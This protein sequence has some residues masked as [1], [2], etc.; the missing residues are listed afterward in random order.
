MSVASTRPSRTR[1]HGTSRAT[2]GRVSAAPANSGFSP[3]AAIGEIFNGVQWTP[4]LVAFLYYYFVV[5]TYYLPGADVGMV[6]AVAMLVLQLHEIRI[7]RVL[8]LLAF[9]VAWMWLSYLTSPKPALAL[10]QTWTMTKLWIVAFVAFNVLRTR[11]QI[12]FFLAFATGCFLLF[13]LRGALLNYFLG[14]STGGRAA[15]NYTYN[16]PNDLAGFAIIFASIA[17]SLAPITR[18]RFARYLC[19]ASAG[20][21]VMLIFFTQSRGALLATGIIASFLVVTRFRRPS[22]VLGTVVTLLMAAYFAPQSVWNRLGGLANV[23]VEGGMK[24][25]DKEGSAEQRFQLLTVASRIALDHPVTGIGAGTYQ[26]MHAEYARGM[27]SELPLAGGKKDAH[28]TYMH[29]AAE[30]GF[31]GLIIFLGLVGSSI[32]ASLRVARRAAHADGETLRM[33]TYGLVGFLLAGIFGS[34]EYINVLHLHLVL[35]ESCALAIGVSMNGE[36][37]ARNKERRRSLREAPQRPFRA[38]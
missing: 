33:L 20:T 32:V 14:Y 19:F 34:L 3:F 25:V 24:G 28:N 17:L 36:R 7:G 13:P 15:W 22:V 35:L 2:T 6:I 38:P 23:S 27:T 29:T 21:M 18:N 4:S 37:G 11:A 12:R 9:W 31:V 16:N 26:E 8:T 10:D 30:L 1:P 5:I